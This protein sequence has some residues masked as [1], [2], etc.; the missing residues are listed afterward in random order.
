MVFITGDTHI[1]TDIQKLS[2]TRFPVQKKL[3]EKDYLII[4][5]DFGGVWSNSNE[6]I[7]WRKWLNN[8]NFL[9]LFIDGNHENFDLLKE[10]PVVDFNGGKAHKIT[11]K[12]FHLMRGQIYTIDNNKIFTFGG[13]SSH[14]KEYR[15]EGTNWWSDEMP[16]NEEYDEAIRNLELE[17]WDV[18]YIITHCTAT[19]I[20]RQIDCSY[21]ENVLTDFLESIKEKSN[22][23]KW[24]FIFFTIRSH[25]S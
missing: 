4:C 14:D 2:T 25:T 12:I 11:D 1:P 18:D 15:K 8:K 10:F 20:Q 17:N 7:Y 16:T 19:S 9:T 24:L 6:E 21:E 23:K 3:T 22:Y 13:A 5:G